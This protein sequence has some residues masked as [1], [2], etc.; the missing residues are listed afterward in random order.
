MALK[1]RNTQKNKTNRRKQQNKQRKNLKKKRQSRRRMRRGAA[2]RRLQQHH[3]QGKTGEINNEKSSL[4]SPK[5]QYL[6]DQSNWITLNG[7]RSKVEDIHLLPPTMRT[8]AEE[9]KKIRD[10]QKKSEL[11]KNEN[12][13]NKKI[14]NILEEWRL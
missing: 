7:V 5:S 12:I 13:H 8:K 9:S 3:L 6:G 4:L 10:W 1:S 2:Q 14:S 11:L